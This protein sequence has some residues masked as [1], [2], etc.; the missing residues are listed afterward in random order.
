MLFE[1]EF[2]YLAKLTQADFF[3]VKSLYIFKNWTSLFRNIW[4]LFFWEEIHTLQALAHPNG[5]PFSDAAASAANYDLILHHITGVHPGWSQ[6]LQTWKAHISARDPAQAV[7]GY[8]LS[9]LLPQPLAASSSNPCWVWSSFC[10]ALLAGWSHSHSSPEVWDPALGSSCSLF[11]LLWAQPGPGTSTP[12]SSPQ[13]RWDCSPWSLPCF[14]K[15]AVLP[16]AA[17]VTLCSSPQGSSPG[18]EVHKWF[19]A[20][21]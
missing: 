9:P 18:E 13:T 15:W 1:M 14:Q 6:H 10:I 7:F 17:V 5:F 16:A 8:Q 3:T 19:L 2:G 12:P 20:K 4:I 11:L 21:Q